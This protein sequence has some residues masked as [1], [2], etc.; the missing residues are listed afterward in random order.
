MSMGQQQAGIW[1]WYAAAKNY[2]IN[3]F[4]R[5][6]MPEETKKEV[7]KIQKIERPVSKAPERLGLLW[8][9]Y[10]TAKNYIASFFDENTPEKRFK[11]FGII[12]QNVLSNL[13]VLPKI[14]YLNNWT[15]PVN[16]L[17]DRLQKASIQGLQEI[18]NDI[19]DVRKSLNEFKQDDAS[20]MPEWLN[21]Q[22]AY[23]LLES[24]VQNFLR[25]GSSQQQKIQSFVMSMVKKEPMKKIQFLSQ[26]MLHDK[27]FV[28]G[29][30][31]VADVTY[32]QL[33][34]VSQFEVAMS[35][36][37]YATCPVQA[38]R[39][40]EL[41]L[42]YV[43]NK[44]DLTQL[45]SM[46]DMIQTLQRARTVCERIEWGETE[47]IQ[48]IIQNIVAASLQGKIT[49]IENIQYL[50]APGLFPKLDEQLKQVRNQFKSSEE[51]A[52]AFVLGTGDE[53]LTIGEARMHWFA[54]AIVKQENSIQVLV[55]DSA[56][57]RNHLDAGDLQR[58]N[59][60]ITY[61]RQ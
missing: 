7:P 17:S 48:N 50:N 54:V 33:N 35:A 1:A 59:S 55:A 40:A 30:K 31:Q 27:R 18:L 53:A 46:Q 43:E 16:T 12:D 42:N 61:L 32:I 25:S 13:V 19:R 34:A 44:T 37:G 38:V 23:K 39:N 15:E 60:L 8:S 51:F 5:S 29:Y 6:E 10:Y 49:V 24:Q 22:L 58:L 21:P 36:I 9:W 2:L 45:M 14:Q 47:D 26:E 28:K 52:H 41:L 11:T 56:P 4:K 57:G 20:S 3:T